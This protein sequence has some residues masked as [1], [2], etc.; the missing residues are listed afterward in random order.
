MAC[1]VVW[2]WKC[3]FQRIESGHVLITCPDS[4]TKRNTAMCSLIIVID[5]RWIVSDLLAGSA[6]ANVQLSSVVMESDP[7]YVL[8]NGLLVLFLF[9][10]SLL[11]FRFVLFSFCYSITKQSSLV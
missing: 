5:A 3:I 2:P 4:V 9:C 10:L 7:S 6:C 1:G 8:G 11:R